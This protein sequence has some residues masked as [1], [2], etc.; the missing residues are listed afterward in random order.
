MRIGHKVGKSSY[1]SFGKSGTYVSTKV[2]GYRISHLA[3]PKKSKTSKS[4]DSGIDNYTLADF[5]I[6]EPSSAEPSKF[7]FWFKVY[8]GVIIGCIFLGVLVKLFGG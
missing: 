1:I 6:E 2:G 8:F 5:G 3:R 4:T 7:W